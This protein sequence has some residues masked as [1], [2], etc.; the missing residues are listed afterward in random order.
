MSAVTVLVGI[1]NL[2]P[3][4]FDIETSGFDDAAEVTVAG[5]AHDFGESLILKRPDSPPTGM[6]WSRRSLKPL[7]EPSSSKLST[8]SGRCLKRLGRL[9]RINSTATGIT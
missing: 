9:R 6:R 3:I 2:D 1:S 7:L 8:T 4:A 5:F